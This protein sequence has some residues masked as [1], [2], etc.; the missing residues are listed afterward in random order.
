MK[1]TVL[2]E[3]KVDD[4]PED[5]KSTPLEVFITILGK[6]CK[7][8]QGEY[9]S[10][11]KGTEDW[12]RRYVLNL[13]HEGLLEHYSITFLIKGI[14]RVTSH[15]LVR[16]RIAS[17]LQQSQRSIECYSIGPSVVIPPKVLKN[18]AA[19]EVYNEALKVAK[20]AYR[21]LRRIG[22]PKED[23]R[24]LVPGGYKT[25]IIMTV[26]LRSLRNMLKLRLDK[27]AQWEIREMFGKILDIMKTRSGVLF[28]S[29]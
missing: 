7:N 28:G 5:K 20:E 26:N 2:A 8:N 10:H 27:H 11:T 1:V 29:S 14:S 17:Y 18:R 15:Q 19:L 25:N 16:H 24:Y 22:I 13:G 6:F 3:T 23:A 21:K 9:I 4:L 12:I